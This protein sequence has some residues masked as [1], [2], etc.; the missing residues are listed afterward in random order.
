MRLVFKLPTKTISYL[1]IFFFF[2]KPPINSSTPSNLTVDV[3]SYFSE[4][5]EETGRPSLF[6]IKA[7]N[8]CLPGVLSLSDYPSSITNNFDLT[9]ITT[10][11]TSIGFTQAL[12]TCFRSFSLKVISSTIPHL[13]PATTPVS[14]LPLQKLLKTFD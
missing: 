3:T 2:L 9:V 1:I 12:L 5:M 4:K 14:W 13:F 8:Q 11:P 10:V 6:Y 7:T